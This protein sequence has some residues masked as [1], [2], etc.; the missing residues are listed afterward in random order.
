MDFDYYQKKALN[1]AI[2]PSVGNN[3]TYPILGLS[4]E[5]GEVAEKIK[6]II[7]DKG[8]IWSAKD[9]N[10]ICKEL[11]D[12]LWYIALIAHEFNLSLNNVAEM[13]IKKLSSRLDR[14]KIQGNGDNR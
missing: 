5:T 2:Y 1:T 14:N 9:S 8:G 13:N 11:G 3:I 7:R 4:G 6:K 10:E 12:V